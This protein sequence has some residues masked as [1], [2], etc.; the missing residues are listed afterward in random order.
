MPAPTR[1]GDLWSS[2]KGDLELYWGVF[3][4]ELSEMS[5]FFENIKEDLRDDEVNHAMSIKNFLEVESAWSNIGTIPQ[6]KENI[7]FYTVVS[8][9]TKYTRREFAQNPILLFPAINA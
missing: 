3:L 8:L 6:T 5:T 7:I 1:F 9:W 4:M 2:F